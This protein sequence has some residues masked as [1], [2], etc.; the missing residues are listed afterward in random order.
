MSPRGYALVKEHPY[1]FNKGLK[2]HLDPTTVSVPAYAFEAVPFRWL[3]E[4]TV[5]Q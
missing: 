4:E 5:D 3:S 2:G 1:R